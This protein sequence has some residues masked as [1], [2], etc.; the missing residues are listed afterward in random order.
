MHWGACGRVG[1]AFPRP[2]GAKKN[3]AQVSVTKS[4]LDAGNF[5]VLK[6]KS[7]LDAGHFSYQ[8][9]TICSSAPHGGPPPR[10]PAFNCTLCHSAT[11]PSTTLPL[12]EAVLASAGPS[13]A[14]PPAPGLQSI[15]S[16]LRQVR[17]LRKLMPGEGFYMHVLCYLLK[18]LKRYAVP[19]AIATCCP[20][21]I[22]ALLTPF[23]SCG[24]VLFS[25]SCIFFR[26][27][28]FASRSLPAQGRLK[29]RKFKS[30]L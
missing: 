13:L 14:T 8:W 24:V 29:G 5:F 9:P 18:A 6:P 22:R 20:G 1:N 15:H 23:L 11:R 25:L 16:G 21:S 30:G 10:P 26:C 7:Y 2:P 3:F 19:A 28:A 17:F 12:Q 4:Y 27:L